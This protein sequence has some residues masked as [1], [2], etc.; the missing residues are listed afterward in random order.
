MAEVAQDYWI[1]SSLAGE[2]SRGGRR[3]APPGSCT[4]V[5]AWPGRFGCVLSDGD[6][7]I[8]CPL[9]FFAAFPRAAI[10][11]IQDGGARFEGFKSP[12]L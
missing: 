3:Q 2:G 6:G 5:P 12:D 7:D 4:P 11:E 9:A 10:R 1:S 8:E